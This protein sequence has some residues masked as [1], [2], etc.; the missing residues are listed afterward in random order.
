MF[1]K[2][3]S[4]TK[5][6]NEWMNGMRSRFGFCQPDRSWE[7]FNNHM[8]EFRYESPRRVIPT[9]VDEYDITADNRQREF[10]MVFRFAQPRPRQKGWWFWL[11]Q[12]ASLFSWARKRV[13]IIGTYIH[14]VSERL[15]YKYHLVFHVPPLNSSTVEDRTSCLM[16]SSSQKWL[17]ETERDWC[18]AHTWMSSSYTYPSQPWI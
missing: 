8:R 4:I 7:H 18:P 5:Q 14:A 11:A 2:K 3:D 13:I 1:L 16:L 10:P 15:H 9:L 17:I 12:A 6:L